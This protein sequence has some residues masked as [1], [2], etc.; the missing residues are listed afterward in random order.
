MGENNNYDNKAEI[1]VTNVVASQPPEQSPIKTLTAHAKSCG[2]SRQKL[3]LWFEG[4][5]KQGIDIEKIIT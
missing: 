2:M 3:V 1:V 4:K 5:N